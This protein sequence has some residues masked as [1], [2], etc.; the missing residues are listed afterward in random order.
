MCQIG[1]S[2]EQLTGSEWQ[3][4]PEKVKG[5]TRGITIHGPHPSKKAPWQIA[6]AWG[7]HLHRVYNWTIESFV[8]M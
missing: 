7:R 3:F 5:A 6:R 8:E 4:V 1:F 2:G